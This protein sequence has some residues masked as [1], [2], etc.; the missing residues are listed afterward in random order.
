M[1]ASEIEPHP[2][3]WRTHNEAQGQALRGVLGEVGSVAPVIARRLPDGRWQL[4]DGHYRTELHGDQ[5]IDVCEVEL[6]DEEAAKVLASLDPIGA[7]AGQDLEKLNQLVEGIAVEDPALEALFAE[8]LAGDEGNGEAAADARG[9]GE[10]DDDEDGEEND[11]LTAEVVFQLVVELKT[12]RAQTKLTNELRQ[13]GYQV[14]KR[15]K[16]VAG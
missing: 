15:R 14:R 12:K 8:L 11:S 5:E 7:L 6:S 2:L 10:E 13:R 1:R 3:N 9:A 4:I 16:I